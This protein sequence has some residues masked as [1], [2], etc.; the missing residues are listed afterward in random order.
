M[1]LASV[2][3]ATS[4]SLASKDTTRPN[5]DVRAQLDCLDGGA[6][7]GISG[8]GRERVGAHR[9][10]LWPGRAECD[11]REGFSREDGTPCDQPY[12]LPFERDAIGGEAGGEPRR[13]ARRE[14]S[15]LAGGSEQEHVR[16][17][18]LHRALHGLCIRLRRIALERS[19]RHV[20]DAIGAE[21]RQALGLT[22]VGGAD[23]DGAD[24]AAG[25]AREA[26]RFGQHLQRD[27][28]DRAFLG[29]GDDGDLHGVGHQITFAS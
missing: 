14:V 28:S 3:S 23:H 16:P 24:G 5:L 7:R 15:S 13:G 27:L 21:L 25:F 9:R 26:A 17:Q 10:N 12:V 20:H 2:R 22:G 19:T 18:G 6:A 4:P 1:M 11:P 29:L 8:R